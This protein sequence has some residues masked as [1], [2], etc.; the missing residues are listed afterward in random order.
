M[1]EAD[2]VHHLGILRTVSL[3]TISRTTERCTAGRSGFFA[4]NNVGSRFGC[5]HP[6]TSYRLYSTLC[7]PI[8]LYGSE[9][10]SVTNTKLNP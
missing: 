1:E 5:L 7:F 6:V 9:L 8:V 10:W 4:L 3:S 2:E